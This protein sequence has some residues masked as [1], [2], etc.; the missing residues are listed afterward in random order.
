MIEQPEL[1]TNFIS[2]G[3]EIAF[4]VVVLIFLFYSVIL[5]YHWFS[6]GTKH[7][8]SML[9]L[10]IYLIVSAPLLLIMSLTL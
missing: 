8:T 7:A 9:S 1:F 3:R 6:Y 10:A 2:V 4:Y 5:A